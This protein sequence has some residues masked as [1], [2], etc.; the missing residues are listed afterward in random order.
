MA[1]QSGV[2]VEMVAVEA[3]V[4]SDVM[5]E[6]GKVVVASEAERARHAAFL[7]EFVKGHRWG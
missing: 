4:R 1:E 7:G 5:A 6:H 3:M 2:T